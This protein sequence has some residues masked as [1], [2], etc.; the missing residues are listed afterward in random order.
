MPQENRKQPRFAFFQKVYNQS[1][2]LG[3]VKNL[4]SSGCFISTDNKG[5]NLS[6]LTFELPVTPQI[7]KVVKI[8]C[9]TMWR[10]RNG[11][12]AIFS[13]NNENR[14]I[15]SAWAFGKKFEEKSIRI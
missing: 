6:E 9:K 4:S 11:I 7:H 12:G 5:N 8:K 1:K 2:E 13:P 3:I 10:N 15:L 14:K